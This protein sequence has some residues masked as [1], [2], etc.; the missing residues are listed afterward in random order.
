[1]LGD[2]SDWRDL[3]F[4][5]VSV[6]WLHDEQAAL[7]GSTTNMG[8]KLS[9]RILED[10]PEEESKR[11]LKLVKRG[12]RLF[13]VEAEL[14]NQLISMMSRSHRQKRASLAGSLDNAYYALRAS[15]VSENLKR[16][17]RMMRDGDLRVAAG[18]QAE[19][20]RSLAVIWDAVIRAGQE[21]A[22]AAE[23]KSDTEPSDA[24]SRG[25]A[26]DAAFPD[27][28]S[29]LPAGLNPL[30]AALDRALILGDQA[31]ARM[32]DL[33][34]GV[35]NAMTR[36]S[37]IKRN[38]IGAR[39]RET[40]DAVESAM[41][42]AEGARDRLASEMIAQGKA[43]FEQVQQRLDQGRIDGRTLQIQSDAMDMLRDVMRFVRVC[44]LVATTLEARKTSGDRDELGLPLT[45]HGGELKN[46]GDLLI[47]L[48][49]A[50]LLES[51]ARRKVR[52]LGVPAWAD[53]QLRGMEDLNQSN[54]R[55]NHT[56]AVALLRGI[57]SMSDGFSPP[58]R[59]RLG[60]AGLDL[61]LRMKAGAWPDAEKDADSSAV[62]LEQ[63]VRAL[64]QAIENIGRDVLSE[65]PRPEIERRNEVRRIMS[66]ESE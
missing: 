47:D 32:R 28:H 37:V 13:G 62:A 15:R 14:E 27:W 52:R 53:D 23:V 12:Q 18:V 19:T 39:Q 20:L 25:R 61:V 46:L 8:G 65:P 44:D 63:T 9:G 5:A 31:F 60:E 30:P 35:G 56:K 6:T 36:F 24:P 43:E 21:P 17:V 22:R 54:A 4:L 1:V 33:E 41:K 66:E 38:I 11:V 26:Y 2:A 64:R 48:N 10:W 7:L 16:C 59:T 40:L 55:K 45:V 29:G 50:D 57:A 58:V 34:R 42:K 51:D 3:Q 49:A